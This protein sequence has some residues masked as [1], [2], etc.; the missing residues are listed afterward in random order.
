MSRKH[1]ENRDLRSFARLGRVNYGDKTLVA[2]KSATIGIHLLGKI[3]Y[4]TKYCGW[5]FYYNND[6]K[7]EPQNQSSD[8]DVK[9]KKEVHK[10]TNKK[11]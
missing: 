6:V 5:S 11:K 4:L 9:V 2:S 3:D 7:P 8:V 1:D 10:L